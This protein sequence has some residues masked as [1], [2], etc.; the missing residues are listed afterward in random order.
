MRAPAKTTA[1]S[2][3]TREIGF[4]LILGLFAVSFMLGYSQDRS[5]IASSETHYT[6]PSESGLAIVPAS[7]PSSP[8]YEG[9]CTTTCTAQYFCGGTSGN[10]RYYR[11]QSCAEVFVESCQWGCYNGQCLPREGIT[12]VPFD[13]TRITGSPFNATGHLQVTPNLVRSG[14][15]TRVYWQVENAVSCSV[16]GTN[17]D[18][19][20]GLFSG[21]Q[22]QI[23]GAIG[24]QVVYTL[25]CEGY[26]GTSPRS[27]IENAVVNVVPVWHGDQTE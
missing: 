10:D 8:H 1:I 18:Y 4:L 7:C 26:D 5:G 23:T 14:D 24:Q 17:G 25:S 3:H 22:G 12:F 11:N 27:V 6:D 20:E 19:W 2:L 9:Q 21:A 13:G 16:S 15:S